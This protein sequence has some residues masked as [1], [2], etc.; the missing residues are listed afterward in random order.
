MFVLSLGLIYLA[1]LFSERLSEFRSLGLLGIFFIN[2]LG[3]ATLFLPAPAIATV[4]AGGI[5]YPP[6]AV[7]VVSALGSALGDVIGFLLGHSGKHVVFGKK[8]PKRIKAIFKQFRRFGNLL[9]FVAALIPNPFFDLIGII[10]GALSFSLYR[11][12]AL[13]FLGRLIRDLLLAYTGFVFAR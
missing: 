1:F 7:A 8:P 13:L 6:L 5:L 12:F 2:F 9:I 3:S 11:F 10:A 4:V